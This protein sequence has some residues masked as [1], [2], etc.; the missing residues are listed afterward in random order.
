MVYSTFG[1]NEA[2][3]VRIEASSKAQESGAITAI[4][5]LNMQNWPRNR[6]VVYKQHSRLAA[7]LIALRCLVSCIGDV[8]QRVVVLVRGERRMNG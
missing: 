5:T 7:T 1:S 4:H 2:D 6:I 8:T 3:N